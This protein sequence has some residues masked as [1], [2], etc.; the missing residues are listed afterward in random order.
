MAG[1]VACKTAL[2]TGA[3]RDIGRALALGLAA[4]AAAGL[5]LV[6]RSAGQLAETRVSTTPGIWQFML[7]GGDITG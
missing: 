2:I 6:A 3:G 5:I 7:F 1:S 4:A